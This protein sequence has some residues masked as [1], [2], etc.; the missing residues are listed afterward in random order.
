MRRNAWVEL[1][2]GVLRGNLGALRAVLSPGTQ[3]I[4]VVKA[5]AYGHGMAAVAREAVA[6]GVSWFL[7]SRMDEA[8]ELRQS[9]PEGRILLLGAAWSCDLPELLANRITPVLVSE[10]QGRVLAA[11]ARRL[12][13][14]LPCHAK[15]DTGMGRFGFAWEDAAA[16][17]ARLR[18]EGGLAVEG[19]SMH[20]ASAGRPNDP[21]AVLQEER[22]RQVVTECERLGFTGLFRHIANSAAFAGQPHWD[23]DGVRMG[24]LG[25]GYGGRLMGLRVST[26][27]FLQWKTRIVQVKV[28]PAGFPVGYLSTH[29]TSAP[30]RL[31]TID[32]GY[33][34]GFSRLMSNK[35]CVL[36]GGRRAPVVGRVSMNFT[37]VDVGP[38]GAVREGDEVVLIG[39]QGAEAVWADELARW[40]QTIPYEILTNIRSDA[41]VCRGQSHAVR[42]EGG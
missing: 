22:F 34:D 2:F 15:I 11:E 14:V 32:V 17:L 16:A 26:K 35:G 12:G 31:A 5:N 7:V 39:Q 1:D 18:A 3:I 41:V 30:T 10:E 33:S 40:C 13:A 42:A 28:V 24:I 9:L 23:L 38:E 8:V 19:V 27:P 29:V 37:T 6:G 20:F 25:Y 36:L 21:F 4:L